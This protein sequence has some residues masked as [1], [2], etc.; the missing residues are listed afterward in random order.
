MDAFEHGG[1]AAVGV[2]GAVDPG[3]AMIA[4]DD[5]VVFLVRVGAVDGAD[6]VPDGANFVVLHEVHVDFYGAGAAEVIGEREAALPFARSCGAVEGGEDRRGVLIGERV[7]GDGGLV[8]L[9]GVGDAGGVGEVGGGGDA[10][11]LRVAGV[12]REELHA[13]ALDGGGGA[14]GAARVHVAAGVA[15]VGGVRVDDD[16]GGAALL[17]EVDL[18]AAK[19]AAVAGDDDLAFYADAEVFKF[20]KVGEGTVVGVDNVGSDVTGGGGA[21][22]GWKDTGVVLEGVAAVGFGVDVL[23]GGAGHQ[24]LAGGVKGVDLDRDGLVEPDAEGDDLGV[25]A[26][27]LEFFG[28]VEGRCV[29]LGG[30]G[31]VGLGGEGLQV[32]AGEG[33]VGDGEERCIPRLLLGEVGVAEDVGRSGLSR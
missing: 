10:G 28:D 6:D 25:E 16:A 9:G 15:V 12:E 21:V 31:P 18:D 11:S 14:I 32:L 27:R 33:G 22:E 17:G 8:E 1:G 3:V 29:V 20:F 19:V 30:A 13:A 26:G 2:Y 7:G 5:P 23:G 24:L 4:G